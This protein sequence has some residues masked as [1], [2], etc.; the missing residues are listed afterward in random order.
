MTIRWLHGRSP[1]EPVA[2]CGLGATIVILAAMPGMFYAARAS[3]EV[4]HLPPLHSGPDPTAAR[5]SPHAAS[6]AS[7]HG[8]S[9]AP[10]NDGYVGSGACSRCHIEIYNHFLR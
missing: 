4:D 7:P 10:Q 9:S 1:N 3:A 5:E 2:R 6:R 8:A